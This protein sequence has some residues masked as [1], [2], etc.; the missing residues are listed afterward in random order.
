V[1]NKG[2][3][4][5]IGTPEE[6]YERPTTRFVADFLGE[7]NFLPGRVVASER[8]SCRVRIG[9]QV[10]DA[11]TPAPVAPGALVVVA[12]RPER[13]KL[14]PAAAD[15]EGLSGKLVDIVYLGN[16]RR[17]IVRLSD[18]RDCFVLQHATQADALTLAPGQALQL[19]WESHH[20]TVFADGDTLA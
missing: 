5:Q 13:L 10:F 12:V 6:L 7:T 16:A 9:N 17:S 4:E 14:R 18:G 15:G 11:Q 20:A 8:L 2:R 3:I 19:S 1:F